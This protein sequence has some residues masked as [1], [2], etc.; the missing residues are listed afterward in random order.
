MESRYYIG[1]DPGMSNG[2]IAVLSDDGDVVSSI[3]CPTT[4]TEIIEALSIYSPQRGI[5]VDKTI[6]YIEKLWGH[7]GLMGSKASI[8]SQAENYGMLKM[9]CIAL[10]MTMIEITP[11]TWQKAYG[12][13]KEKD[14]SPKEW[15]GLLKDRAQKLFPQEKVTNW[16]ADALL[17][18]RHCWKEEKGGTNDR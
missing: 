1:I 10:K 7:G 12:M 13:K 8:W 3:K 18:A 16:S 6:V 5:P 11:G 17:L 4:D 9:A 2:G 14:Q 15:K